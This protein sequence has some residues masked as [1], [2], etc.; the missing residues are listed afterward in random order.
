MSQVRATAAA[1]RHQP[2]DEGL[3]SKSDSSR[4]SPPQ[5]T[6]SPEQPASARTPAVEASTA[7]SPQRR[8]LH[9]RVAAATRQSQ[10][11][12]R[13]ASTDLDRRPDE[14]RRGAAAWEL[15]RSGL[16]QGGPPYM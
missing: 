16:S 4:A 13:P 7:A 3:G 6:P 10:R 5:T 12:R 14:R 1:A 9:G 8:G 15:A 2:R 11:P